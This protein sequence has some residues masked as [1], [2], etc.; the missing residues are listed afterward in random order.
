MH[1]YK[2]FDESI[3]QE[4]LEEGLT[5]V[6]FWTKV[7]KESVS[8]ARSEEKADDVDFGQVNLQIKWYVKFDIAR[9]ITVS[10]GGRNNSC[11]RQI[12]VLKSVSQSYEKLLMI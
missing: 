9:S 4:D 5:P 7:A 8:L 1:L 11:K 6:V 2:D 10:K 3:Y 12:I